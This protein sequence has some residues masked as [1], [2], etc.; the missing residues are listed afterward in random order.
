VRAEREALAARYRQVRARTEALIEPLT[1]EDCGLQSMPDA[2]PAKWHLAH[3]TWFFE[4][5][6]LAV[7][8][9]GFEAFHPTFGYLFNSYY[10]AAGPRHARPRRGLLSRPTLDEVRAYRRAV[11]ARTLDLL[12]SA[13]GTAG[14]EVEARVQ[15]GLHH[16]E[17][18]QEL[19]LMD[20]KHAFSQSPLYPAYHPAP[21]Q[22]RAGRG[23][24]PPAGWVEL[25]GG[26]VELGHD[27]RGFAFDNEGP[28][29]PVYLAPYRLADRL[30]TNGEWLAFIAD[31]GYRT[32]ALWLSDGW[33]W[34]QAVGIEAPLYWVEQGGLHQEFTLAG[35]R[36]L[37]LDVPVVHVSLYEADAYARWAGARLP[38]EAEWEHAAQDAPRTGN[39]LDSGRLH[40]APAPAPDGRLRQVYGDAWTLTAS[41][42]G[43]YPGFRPSRGALGEYNGKFMCNQG[44]LRGGSCATP[45][46]HLRVSYRNFFYPHQRWAFQGLRLAEGPG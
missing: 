1:P 44:V 30:V 4:T 31:G 3:T 9:P 25:E 27:G 28:R 34:V 39:T 29:H 21:P 46:A 41:A 6:V 40:P 8:Q 43:P 12:G 13:A 38:T 5:F 36:P 42:Y 37:Q 35:L 7:H 10:E 45:Q 15:L 24:V 26:L 11:D 32:P 14:A 33:A 16:E 17:Q 2:S 18:H 23:D 20:I 22:R 19:L